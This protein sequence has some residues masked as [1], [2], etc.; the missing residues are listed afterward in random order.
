M[1]SALCPLPSGLFERGRVSWGSS[2]LGSCVG[3]RRKPPVLWAR[4]CVGSSAPREAERTDWQ[5]LSP[6][7]DLRI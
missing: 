1:P 2:L 4:A 5:G 6:A 3:S 7:S